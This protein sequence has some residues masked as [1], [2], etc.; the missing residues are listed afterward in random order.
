MVY[1]I[2]RIIGHI[3]VLFSDYGEKVEI[4]ISF[5]PPNSSEGDVL[6]V[7]NHGNYLHDFDMTSSRLTEN[8]SRL[9]K[10]LGK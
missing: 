2:D 9:K 7:D 1:T 5:L 4:E 8:D 10:L 3:A 6:R